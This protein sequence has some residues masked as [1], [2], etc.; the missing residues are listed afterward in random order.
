MSM[1]ICLPEMKFIIHFFLEIL[2]FKESCNLFGQ[3]YFGSLIQNQNLARYGIG[4]EISKTK[5]VLILDDYKEKPM[6]KLFKKSKSLILGPFW[7]LLTKIRQKR[8]F[9]EK[10]Q[11]LVIPISY[12][13]AKSL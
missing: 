8:I 9:P 5:L 3:E 13:C 6:T 7:V 4:G 11:F 2:H 12:H 10:A 1:F